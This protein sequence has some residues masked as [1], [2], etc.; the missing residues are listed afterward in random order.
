MLASQKEVW[1][2]KGHFLHYDLTRSRIDSKNSEF[3]FLGKK[4]M[5]S[6]KLLFILEVTVTCHLNLMSNILLKSVEKNRTVETGSM[7]FW[8]YGVSYRKWL[9]GRER[10][11]NEWVLTLSHCEWEGQNLPA[12]LMDFLLLWSIPWG[13]ELGKDGFIWL[14]F[15]VRLRQVAQTETTEERMLRIGLF[16]YI[17]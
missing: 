6:W 13:K 5:L 16:S 2:A 14:N 1:T 10:P 15:S 8:E 9:K 7:C 12:F 4:K 17:T 11:P 3:Y